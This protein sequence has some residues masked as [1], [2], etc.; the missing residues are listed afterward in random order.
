MLRGLPYRLLLAASIVVLVSLLAGA[1]LALLDARSSD[2]GENVWWAF[3]RLTD[4]GYLGDDEGVARR[5]ISTVVTVLGYV[6]FLG[7]LIAILTQWLNGLISGLQSGVTPIALSDHVIVLGWTHRTPTIVA[8]LLG[9]G[10]RVRR[11][12][13]RRG[14]NDLRIVVLAEQV[15]E[16]LLREL[17]ERVGAPW[18]DR[19]VFLRSGSPLRIDHLERV[20]FR[21]AAVL[22]LPGADFGEHRPEVVDTET[23]KTLMAVSRHASA[24]HAEVPLAVAEIFDGRRAA[25]ARR[26]YAGPSEIL[27]TDEI[28]SRLIVQSVQ[29]QGMCDVFQELLT[30]GV[31]NALFVRQLDD[32]AGRRFGELCGA[33]SRAIPLGTVR[34]GQARPALAPDPETVLDAEDQ[35][36][37]IARRFEDCLPDATPS[38]GG[39]VPPSP[40]TRSE[41]AGRRMLIL[42][43]SRKVPALLE[44]LARV[45]EGAYAVDVVSSTPGPEREAALVRRGATLDGI[46][47]QQIEAGYTDPGVLERLEPARYDNIVLLASERLDH[48]EQADANTVYTY[49]L[50]RGLLAAASPSPRL[51]VE[52]LD[53]QNEFLFARED[54]DRI[55]SPLLVSYLLSQVALR[56]EL[57][58][59]V[60]E[61]SSSAG[62]QIAL[63]PARA[64]LA[65][66]EPARFAD[67]GRAAAARGEI[68]LGVRRAAGAGAELELNPDRETAWVPEDGDEVVVLTTDAD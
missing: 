61:L 5:T 59:V 27:A 6:L 34:P 20:A 3:L 51:F 60:A 11:F 17:R 4:P 14:A 41:P 22:I 47:L 68:A 37:F 36:V 58:A 38:A 15:D 64:Y 43:W 25:V 54:S 30:L 18:S 2:L 10:G 40:A 62:A 50:L 12:L 65:A 16:A 39:A 67:L 49:L 52:L 35:L 8:E 42:G 44:E 33:F 29:Q 48:E 45:R 31:G 66:G 26:A 1:L 9:T 63:R 19:R 55:V 28:V 56:R 46:A 32:L 23:I 24:E 53:A 7:L 13:A 57:G 21:D